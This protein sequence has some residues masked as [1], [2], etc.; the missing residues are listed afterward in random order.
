MGTRADYYVG[1]GLDAE[2]I[3]STAYDG[4]PDGIFTTDPSNTEHLCAALILDEDS[5][6][7]NVADFLAARDDSTVPEQGWPWPWND[8]NTTDYAYAFDEGQVWGNCFGY[9]WFLVDMEVPGGGCPDE[10][11]DPAY[12]EKKTTVFPDMSERKNVRFDKGSGALFI[13]VSG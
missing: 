6:R 5:W 7:D 8:S 2:W 9:G 13:N 11:D 12:W 3:G 10:E 1:R 4:Y